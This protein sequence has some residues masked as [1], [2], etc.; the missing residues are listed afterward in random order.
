MNQCQKPGAVQL[1]I[2]WCTCM[3]NKANDKYAVGVA[4]VKLTGGVEVLLFNENDNLFSHTLR[5][6]SFRIEKNGIHEELN[7]PI[8]TTLRNLNSRI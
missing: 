7:I 6:Y 2:Q 4:M 1:E 8:T 3:C 5:F